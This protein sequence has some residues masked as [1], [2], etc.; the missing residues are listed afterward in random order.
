VVFLKYIKRW[1]IPKYYKKLQDINIAPIFI[2]GTSRSG[3]SMI[4]S[5]I[6]QHPDVEGIFS[7]KNIDN[8]SFKNDHIKAYC[9]SH[10]IWGSIFK[11]YKLITDSDE[12]ILWGHPKHISKHYRDKPKNKK[13]LLLLANSLEYYRLTKK[14]PLINSHFNMLKIGLIKQMFPKAKFILI[15]RNYEDHFKSWHDKFEKVAL[16]KNA[17]SAS[18]PQDYPKI[19]L[20]WATLN[21]CAIYDLKKYSEGSFFIID[22]ASL[23]EDDDSV[24]GNLNRKIPTIGLSTFQFN[25]DHINKD[26]V[27]NKGKN[28]QSVSNHY[29]DFI[30]EIFTFEKKET[31]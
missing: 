18:N 13:E 29:F 1:R 21:S 26:L 28:I 14:I 3:T 22:Y 17:P 10:H 20:Y 5:I 7:S 25:L 4:A 24:I 12:G 19:G 15:I 6:A 9:T 11:Y 16:L 23:F 31:Q 27:F 30:E 8:F 2:L